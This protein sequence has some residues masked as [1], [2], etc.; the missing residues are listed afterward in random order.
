MTAVV[1]AGPGLLVLGLGLEVGVGVGVGVPEGWH[2]QYHWL[3][4][5]Q[6]L[7]SGQQVAGSEALALAGA[8]DSPPQELHVG[9]CGGA[10]GGCV[11]VRCARMQPVEDLT[12]ERACMVHGSGTVLGG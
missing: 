1:G 9:T 5:T 11:C 6:L 12:V 4:K 3:R 7:P 2:C 8:W 10:R